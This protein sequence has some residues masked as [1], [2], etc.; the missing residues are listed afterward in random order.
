MLPGQRRGFH[1]AGFLHGPGSLQRAGT[2][3][4][5]AF[6][7]PANAPV[8]Q[9]IS[10]PLK[11]GG[12]PNDASVGDLDGDGGY[13]IVLKRE[14]RTHDNAQTGPTDPTQLEA[15][16]LDGTFMWKIELGINIRGGAHYTQF[17]VYDLDGDGKAEIV[18][19]TADGTVDGV[20]KVIGDAKANYVD[21]RGLI[22]QGPEFLTV[23]DGPTGKALATTDYIPPR[24][25][26]GSSW[27]ESNGNR[28]DRF[29]ACVAYLDGAMEASELE[30]FLL[31]QMAESGKKHIA[32]I[33][34]Q[35]IPRRL[36]EALV[37]LAA[38]VPSDRAVEFAK[39]DRK[40]LVQAV[41]QTVIPV[42]GTL[43][44]R[45][46]EVTAGG[47][48]LQEVDSRTMQSKLVPNLF[49][50]GEL[51]DVDGPIDGYNFQAAFST[52]ALA[53]ESASEA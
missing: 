3:G 36:A 21:Q 30:S 39:E 31:R 6:Q 50:A 44:F 1:P 29:L 35:L 8:R 9:Y 2:T 23:F 27:G 14:G 42:A 47:V 12:T 45:K 38:I 10:I 51:L 17:M 37:Q 43:G 16:K 11:P 22:I 25:G 5:R 13:E 52:G 26:N 41:K 53:G 18:C 34:D 20:G 48:S 15:Y 28:V 46:A 7:I 40:R 32:G 19:K 4:R 33:L 24:G 49:F